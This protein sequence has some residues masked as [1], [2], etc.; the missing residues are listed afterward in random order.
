[1][2]TK[3]TSFR[4]DSENI[5]KLRALAK[6]EEISA[7]KMINKIIKDFSLGQKEIPF[8]NENVQ[9]SDKLEKEL[10]IQKQRINIIKNQLDYLIRLKNGKGFE[11]YK[12]KK[13]NS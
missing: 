4:L 11:R 2:T 12:P 8:S 3:P 6:R 10:S 13:A 9:R 5:S 1:M 7:N